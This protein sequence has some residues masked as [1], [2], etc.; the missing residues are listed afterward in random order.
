MTDQAVREQIRGFILRELLLDAQNTTIG[1]DTPLLEDFKETMGA[2]L[3]EWTS[4]EA[5]GALMT[6]REVAMPL[7]F[8]GSEAA[9]YVNGHDLVADGGFTAAM[10]TGQVDLSAIMG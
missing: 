8:L 1:D 10:T 3:I 4:K 7:A 9:S 2:H 5:T 6:P